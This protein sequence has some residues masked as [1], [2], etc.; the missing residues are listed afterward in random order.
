DDE[1]TS[2]VF[3]EQ[4][5][6]RSAKRRRTVNDTE[7]VE[8]PQPPTE[9][10]T[11]DNRGATL[12]INEINEL[13]DST[14]NR[15]LHVSRSSLKF[16]TPSHSRTDDPDINNTKVQA[17]WI[18][19]LPLASS[20]DHQERQTPRQP[21]GLQEL[22]T[23]GLPL[24]IYHTPDFFKVCLDDGEVAV[25]KKDFKVNVSNLTRLV[26]MDIEKYV[27]QRPDLEFERVRGSGS[28]I[29]FQD[30]IEI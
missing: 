8:L 16:M 28:Y 5:D 2:S 6:T 24:Q 15:L 18:P 27:Q 14:I 10:F 22:Q 7:Q 23:Q 17:R 4:L 3:R 20:H 1:R 25:R 11:W 30:T 19:V 21:P 29:D 9:G 12:Q 26:S 13:T